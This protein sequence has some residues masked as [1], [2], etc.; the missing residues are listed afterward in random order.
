MNSV[1]FGRCQALMPA[2]IYAARLG[3]V[4]LMQMHLICFC[5]SFCRTLFG[6]F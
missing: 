2:N 3:Q 5:A 4:K 6:S 1:A